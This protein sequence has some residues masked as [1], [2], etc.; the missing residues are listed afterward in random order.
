MPANLWH[1]AHVFDTLLFSITCLMLRKIIVKARG[2]NLKQW[3]RHEQADNCRLI[4]KLYR[5]LTG[6]ETNNVSST[7]KFYVHQN[8]LSYYL[9]NFFDWPI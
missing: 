4:K 6:V 8:H 7:L 3:I 9:V 2:K 5:N 1:S